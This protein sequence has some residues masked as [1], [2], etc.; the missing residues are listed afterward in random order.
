MIRD[1]AKE[2]VPERKKE[3]NNSRIFH[4]FQNEINLF[5]QSNAIS[6]NCSE[7]LSLSIRNE[8]NN[9]K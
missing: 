1:E 5:I 3:T 8:I 2:N 7:V 6:H 4:A 9:R